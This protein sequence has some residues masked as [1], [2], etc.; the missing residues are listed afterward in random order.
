M[1]V[2][3]VYCLPGTPHIVQKDMPEDLACGSGVQDFGV[4]VYGLGFRAWDV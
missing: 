2:G 3:F 4:R 1:L